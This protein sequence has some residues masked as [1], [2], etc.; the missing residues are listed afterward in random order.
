MHHMSALLPRSVTS[1]AWFVAGCSV[2]RLLQ[3]LNAA[4]PS[5]A[6]LDDTPD[7]MGADLTASR[8]DA[9]DE[10]CMAKVRQ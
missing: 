6:D 4:D 3:L 2:L 10:L 8:Q 1:L 9:W 5:L 7:H